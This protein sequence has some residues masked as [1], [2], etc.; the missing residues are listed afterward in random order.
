MVVFLPGGMLQVKPGSGRGG[1][2]R[3]A[4]RPVLVA[5]MGNRNIPVRPRSFC[6]LQRCTGGW[7]WGQAHLM[8]DDFGLQGLADHCYEQIQA[9]KTHGQA[10]GAGRPGYECPGKKH[11]ACAK[12]RQNIHQRGDAGKRE[13]G[14]N[15]QHPGNRY[16]VP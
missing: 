4:V 7:L 13:S 6:R 11:G 3:C 5:A 9:H 14:R 2:F 8:A 10:S 12:D 1:Y 15:A 16:K